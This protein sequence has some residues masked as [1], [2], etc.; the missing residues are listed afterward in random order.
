[1][2]PVEEFR[3]IYLIYLEVCNEN[4]TDPDI[5][6]DHYNYLDVVKSM[7]ETSLF[8]E[9][10]RIAVNDLYDRVRSLKGENFV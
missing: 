8:D 5:L 3:K 10:C 4:E 9:C 1:M 2:K 7:N 6:E